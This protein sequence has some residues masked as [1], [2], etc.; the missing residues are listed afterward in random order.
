MSLYVWKTASI[1]LP[2]VVSVESI[3]S[4]GHLFQ[5]VLLVDPLLNR[6]ALQKFRVLESK[7]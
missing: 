5:V 1:H 6:K 7:K 4:A 3:Q 2:E